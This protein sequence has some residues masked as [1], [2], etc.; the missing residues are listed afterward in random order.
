MLKYDRMVH[1]VIPQDKYNRNHNMW[2]CG[3][4]LNLLTVLLIVNSVKNTGCHLVKSID[5]EVTLKVMV[6]V[7]SNTT[8]K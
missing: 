7:K 8:I 3:V 4:G 6:K 1:L 5:S 2:K